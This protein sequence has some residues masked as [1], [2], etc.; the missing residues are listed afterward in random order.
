MSLTLK[1]QNKFFSF[2]CHF[3]Y[4]QNMKVFNISQHPE[5]S[6]KEGSITRVLIGE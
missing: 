4:F 3:F 5:L 2:L 1:I 6:D